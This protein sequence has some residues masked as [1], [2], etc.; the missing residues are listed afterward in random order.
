MT[1]P[2]IRVDL[3][4]IADAVELFE[5]VRTEFVN[6]LEALNDDLRV[7]LALW[8]GE[9]RR[10]YDLVQEEWKEAADDMADQVAYLRHWLT[11]SHR[12]F[13]GALDATLKTWQV[14]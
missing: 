7:H 9:S 8:E 4:S 2:Q 5:Q 6:C 3:D 14:D 12:N 13:S 1:E 11:I 10:A